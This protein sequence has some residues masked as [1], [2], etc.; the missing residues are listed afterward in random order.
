MKS[1]ISGDDDLSLLEKL[2]QFSMS[3]SGTHCL[4]DF[5]PVTGALNNRTALHVDTQTEMCSTAH[6]NPLNLIVIVR[7][8]STAS[9]LVS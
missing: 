2:A 4:T 3:Y 6:G 8:K 1:Y 5:D 7:N 9:L